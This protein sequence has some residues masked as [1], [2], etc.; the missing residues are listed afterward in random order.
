MPP[1]FAR[2]RFLPLLL[3]NAVGFLR[4]EPAAAPASDADATTTTMIPAS[5]PRLQWIGRTASTAEGTRKLAYPGV[6]L[7]FR[8]AGAAPTLVFDAASPDCYFNLRINGWDPQIVRLTEGR[9]RILL[10][11]GPAPASGW[12]VEWVRRNESWQ[13]IATVLGLEL[14]SDTRLLPPAAVASAADPRRLLVIGDSITS[15]HFIEQMPGTPD[16]SPRTNNAER[17][18]GW[19]LAR[20]LGAEVNIVAYGGRGLTRTW[21]GRT[22]QSTAPQFFERAQPDDPASVWDHDRYQPDAIVVMLGQNDFNLGIVPE[23]EFVAA[24]DAFVARLHA[25][26]P[27][28]ALVLANSPMHDPKPGTPD[29]EKRAA[30]LRYTE[31]VAEHARAAG[32]SRVTTVA[33]SHQPGTSLNAHPVAFQHEQIVGEIETTVRELTG[34]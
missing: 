20:R 30:L 9:N 29:A 25:V 19:L 14:G 15:G 33:V 8:Y 5:D 16:G 31:Q 21:E 7:R 34:W 23:A 32:F 1:S 26:H 27:S 22:D 12:E 28:A 17:T 11:A 4:A 2:L 10:P 6:T 24:Y 13:G 3:L 18:W